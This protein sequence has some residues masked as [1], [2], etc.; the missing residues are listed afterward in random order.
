MKKPKETIL[1][2]TCGEA[3]HGLTAC[4]L[5]PYRV[6]MTAQANVIASV[7]VMAKSPAEALEA[8][9]RRAKEGD[10]NWRYNGVEDGTVEAISII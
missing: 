2:S 1:C 9:V 5:R 7:E 3:F 4:V 6:A 8:A 10:T